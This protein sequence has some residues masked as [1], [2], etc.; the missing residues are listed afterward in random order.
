LTSELC[1]QLTSCETQGDKH[2]KVENN[3]DGQGQV[4]MGIN[5]LTLKRTQLT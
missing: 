1:S 4:S 3:K 2:I 5:N